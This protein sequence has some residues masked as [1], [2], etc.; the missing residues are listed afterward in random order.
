[1]KRFSLSS[2]F[3]RQFMFATATA[4]LLTPTIFAGQNTKKGHKSGGHQQSSGRHS[5]GSAPQPSATAQPGA[6]TGATGGVKDEFGRTWIRGVV[7]PTQPGTATPPA[8]L[9]NGNGSSPSLPPTPPSRPHRPHGIHRQPER[10]RSHGY[11]VMPSQPR[12]R[13]VFPVTPAPQPNPRG[14]QFGGPQPEPPT[15]LEPIPTPRRPRVNPIPRPRPVPPP[16]PTV[17]ARPTPRPNLLPQAEP[18][19]NVVPQP[20]ANPVAAAE[21]E[22]NDGPVERVR[23]QLTSAER[24]RAEASARQLA[25]SA[26]EELTEAADRLAVTREEIDEANDEIRSNFGANLERIGFDTEEI[27]KFFDAALNGDFETV[28]QML[29]DHGINPDGTGADEDGSDTQFFTS[30]V[31]KMEFGHA[32][33]ELE[34]VIGSGDSLEDIRQAIADVVDARDAAVAAPYGITPEGLA[35]IASAIDESLQSVTDIS[36]LLEVIGGLEETPDGGWAFGGGGL[37]G[38]AGFAPGLGWGGGWGGGFGFGAGPGW[39]LFDPGLA[40]GGVYWIGNGVWLYGSGGECGCVSLQYGTPAVVGLPIPNVEPLPSATECDLCGAERIVLLNPAESGGDVNF[41][42]NNESVLLD[43]GQLQE[44]AA[45]NAIVQFNRGSG[46]QNAKYRLVPGSY[47]F[48]VTD[49]GWELYKTTFKATLDNTANDAE[50]HLMVGDEPTVVPAGEQ[51]LLASDY[52]IRVTFDAGTD[53]EPVTKE[54]ASNEV[55]TI[56]VSQETGGWDLFPGD[57]DASGVGSADDARILAEL[58]GAETE[59]GDG[60]LTPQPEPDTEADP[61]GSDLEADGGASA[62]AESAAT[63]S[64]E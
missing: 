40:P 41:V 3:F 61:V 5:S 50:F 12:H 23:M 15:V 29:R 60:A 24:D 27:A 52:P 14:P 46:L 17:A 30:Y 45:N 47:K 33:D 19:R 62:V 58:G 11:G 22:E 18:P 59:D 49:N 25:Q 7:Q 57:A 13:P 10:P 51:Y 31:R 44:F 20:I 34:R 6:T 2:L 28:R 26:V 1:M 37:G 35:E 53:G 9:P 42:L 63:A 54:L 64:A 38:A 32:L 4:A 39:I 16:Q 55:Y 56:G 21:P 8:T 48:V 36:N 43:A